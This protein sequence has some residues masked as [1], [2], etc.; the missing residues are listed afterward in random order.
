M[1]HFY[2]G[3]KIEAAIQKA[4]KW[5]KPGGKLYVV[6]ERL[7]LK[8]VRTLFLYMRKI[9]EKGYDGPVI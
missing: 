4:F 6:A 3:E 1:L 9:N 8:I 5:L 7:I 2:S